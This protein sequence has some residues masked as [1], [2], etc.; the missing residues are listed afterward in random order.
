MPF[1]FFNTGITTRG[2]AFKTKG[3]EFRVSNDPRTGDDRFDSIISKSQAAQ[4][5]FFSPSRLFSPLRSNRM[6]VAFRISARKKR[7][8]VNGFGVIFADVD[9]ARKTK[10]VFFDKRN[11]SFRTLFSPTRD[12]GLCFVGLCG[13]QICKAKITTGTI[14]LQSFGKKGV[15]SKKRDVVVMDDFLYGEPM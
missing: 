14:S 2:A 10:I 6:N 15:E 5:K 8:C 11:K 1:D 9:V 7:A 12:R 13:V 3:G 4:F